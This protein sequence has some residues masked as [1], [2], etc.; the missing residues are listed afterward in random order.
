MITFFGF[1]WGRGMSGRHLAVPRHQG[2]PPSTRWILMDGALTILCGGVGGGRTLNFRRSA[3]FENYSMYDF[4]SFAFPGTITPRRRHGHQMSFR[5]QVRDIVKTMI[6]ASAVVERPTTPTTP[7]TPD[8]VEEVKD[9]VKAPRVLP[10]TGITMSN[11]R[12]NVTEGD[13]DQIWNL[14]S[15]GDRQRILN[16]YSNEAQETDSVPRDHTE[17]FMHVLTEG[18][19]LALCSSIAKISMLHEEAAGDSERQEHLQ[20][21]FQPFATQLLLRAAQDSAVTMRGTL[22]VVTDKADSTFCEYERSDAQQVRHAALGEVWNIVA[23]LDLDAVQREAAIHQFISEKASRFGLPPQQQVENLL[24]SKAAE[25]SSGLRNEEEFRKLRPAVIREPLKDLN[26]DMLVTAFWADQMN[27]TDEDWVDRTRATLAAI[28][29][30]LYLLTHRSQ[31][32][33]ALTFLQMCEK[34]EATILNTNSKGATF[35][36]PEAVLKILESKAPPKALSETEEYLRILKKAI[37]QL[38]KLSLSENAQAL[39]NLVDRTFRRVLPEKV[40]YRRSSGVKED[41][42]QQLRHSMVDLPGAQKAAG[43]HQKGS[44]LQ[45]KACVRSMVD[46]RRKEALK[47][48]ALRPKTPYL[49]DQKGDAYPMSFEEQTNLQQAFTASLRSLN[50]VTIP[51]HECHHAAVFLYKTLC[52]N[53]EVDCG[54]AT[55]RRLRALNFNGLLAFAYTLNPA[56]AED[57]KFLS[58]DLVYQ[59]LREHRSDF[60]SRDYDSDQI[61]QLEGLLKFC[62]ANDTML[63]YPHQ[64]EPYF[65]KSFRK[66]V[67]KGTFAELAEVYNAHHDTWVKWSKACET[68]LLWNYV[69]DMIKE[70]KEKSRRSAQYAAKSKNSESDKSLTRRMS[71]KMGDVHKEGSSTQ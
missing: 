8:V 57:T 4:E 7:A 33:M 5:A 9:L 70:I 61:E 19:V 24:G 62:R 39:Y 67:N 2:Q 64:K 21:V 32:A 40:V 59:C 56:K 43:T 60:V 53:S 10:K 41:T 35:K 17:R 12:T 1:A 44:Q 71:S 23:N 30:K 31:I 52:A 11:L 28:N 63:L 45:K 42:M 66:I 13:A 16:C 18:S 34:E 54:A 48:L 47:H 38:P 27:N 58:R 51:L 50:I 46:L 37:W 6:E 68:S 22:N 20:K 36:V 15:H 65:V 69:A 3:A 49:T 26:C 55:K 14:L 29:H 25:I